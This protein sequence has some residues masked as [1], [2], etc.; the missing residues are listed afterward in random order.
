[1]AVLK[2]YLYRPWSWSH[3]QSGKRHYEHLLLVYR[4]WSSGGTLVSS[5]ALVWTEAVSPVRNNLTQTNFS[6]RMT[7]RVALQCMVVVSNLTR[8][9]ILRQLVSVLRLLRHDWFL[10]ARITLR[11]RYRLGTSFCW[12]SV[13]HPSYFFR[14][15]LL[16]CG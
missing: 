12:R 2:L 7:L 3:A 11:F 16:S 9:V 10:L 5:F 13:C 6:Q 14:S 1:M 8:I 4:A 15:L